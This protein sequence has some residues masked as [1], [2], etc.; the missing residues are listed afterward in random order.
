MLETIDYY[1]QKMT[2][3]K[4]GVNWDRVRAIKLRELR[5]KGFL[6]RNSKW[7]LA[8]GSSMMFFYLVGF[9]LAFLHD[10]HVNVHLSAGT[11]LNIPWIGVFLSASIM[12]V[13]WLNDRGTNWSEIAEKIAGTGCDTDV[14]SSGDR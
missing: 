14:D 9:V 10:E 12:L 11:I 7:F 4:V 6:A 13:C 2:G 8:A 5:S 3:G 1:V